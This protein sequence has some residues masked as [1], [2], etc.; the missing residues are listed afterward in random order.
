MT[1]ITID[2]TAAKIG[3]LI[4]K[5][6]IF[7][8]ASSYEC[9]TG[10]WMGLPGDVCPTLR[11]FCEG[12]DA[13]LSGHWFSGCAGRRCPGSA[14][15]VRHA[16]THRC[17]HRSGTNTLQPVD[18][19]EVALAQPFADDTQTIHHDSGSYDAILERV[20]LTQN[21]HEF[22]IEIGGDSFFFRQASVIGTA[23]LQPEPGKQ[24]GRQGQ[25]F[26][27]ETRPHANGSGGRTHLVVDKVDAP[28]AGESIFIR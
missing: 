5:P 17:D 13:M 3:R 20:V 14:R 10:S 15:V 8:A 27:G 19:D 21:Q 18:D 16:H 25:V 4:K 11:A 1:K 6:E 12:W 23:A 22:L 28:G 2:T 24:T 7:I 26:V 9:V